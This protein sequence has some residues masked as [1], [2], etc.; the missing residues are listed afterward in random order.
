MQVTVSTQWL[1]QH[2]DDVKILD[3][4]WYLPTEPRDP[5]QEFKDAHIPGAQFFDIDVIADTSSDLPHM[6]PI[7]DAFAEHVQNMGISNSDTVVVYDSHGIFS[8]PRVWWLFRAMGHK[9]VFVLNGGLPQWQAEGRAISSRVETPKRGTFSATLNNAVVVDAQ[10]VLNTSAQ[11]IDA[12][13]FARFAGQA[14]EPRPNTRSGHIPNSTS[15][16]FKSVLTD[17]GHLKENA[18]LQSVFVDAGVNLN[19]PIITSCGSGVTAA[20]LTM[21]LLQLDHPDVA[22]YDGSWSEWGA[23]DDLPIATN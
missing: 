6:V 12:R 10:T 22:L 7:P 15:V 9:D 8:A 17:G 16:F 11:V 21:A 4:S 23:R 2:I 1:A 19:S 18:R 20:V 3:A 13:P 14:A 5:T